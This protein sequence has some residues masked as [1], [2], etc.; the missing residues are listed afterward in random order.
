[1]R[2]RFE[3]RQAIAAIECY[4]A[5]G[6]EG[7]SE[8]PARRWR[9][10]IWSAESGSE[11]ARQRHDLLTVAGPNVVYC[12]HSGAIVALDGAGARRAWAYR[13]PRVGRIPAL[14][15]PRDLCPCISAEGR[16]YSAPADSDRILCLDA[17]SG[18]LVW[19]QPALVVQ[20]LGVSQGRLFATI[21]G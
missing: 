19:E 1:V 2:T 17:R 21:G 14:T 13:S 18:E 10:E 4:D 12:T 15:L 16:L 6:A 20:L 3:G 11:P 7:R 9:Q 8:P 5:E